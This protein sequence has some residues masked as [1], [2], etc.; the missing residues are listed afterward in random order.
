MDN[1]KFVEELV[2][3]YLT[4]TSNNKLFRQAIREAMAQ[5][6]RDAA[7]VVRSLKTGGHWQNDNTREEAALVLE[8]KGG[9][10]EGE[11]APAPQAATHEQEFAQLRRKQSDAEQAWAFLQA[12]GVKNLD[13]ERDGKDKVTLTELLA[14][15][16][17]GVFIGQA[18]APRP[19][20]PTD[21]PWEQ[22]HTKL[23][24]DEG[25][26]GVAESRSMSD[27]RKRELIA[28]R[29]V[30]EDLVETLKELKIAKA[31]LANLLPFLD[32]GGLVIESVHAEIARIDRIL[33]KYPNLK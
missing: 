26:D 1:D 6:Y 7:E 10:V 28:M 16:A 15:F 14:E 23:P 18:E 21:D 13:I 33:D 12:K 8:R 5:A 2:V 30:A 31:H 24:T 4:I 32:L 22:K 17:N 19:S 27:T 20:A 9:L 25:M 11:A 3:G 29:N